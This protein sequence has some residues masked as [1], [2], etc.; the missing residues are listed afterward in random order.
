MLDIESA[1]NRHHIGFFAFPSTMLM[2][3]E[4]LGVISILGLFG[5]ARSIYT[6]HFR[7]SCGRP[8]EK[9]NNNIHYKVLH[10]LS[11]VS[12]P[13]NQTDQT[14]QPVLGIGLKNLYGRSI[15]IMYI[16]AAMLRSLNGIMYKCTCTAYLWPVCNEAS[17]E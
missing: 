11:S 7:Y 5:I 1:L 15:D 8:G 16:H 14:R 3:S 9:S 13:E 2:Y 10:S 6:S 17:K 12:G 4:M